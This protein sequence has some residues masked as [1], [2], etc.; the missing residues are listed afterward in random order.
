MINRLSPWVLALSMLL[1]IGVACA[2]T[3]ALAP[4]HSALKV[5]ATESF[6]ADIAQNVAGSRAQIDTLIP[7]GVD[8][9]SFEPTPADI[10]KVADSH[11]LIIN[12][13]G[14]EAFLERLLQNAG[15]NRLLIEASKGLTSRKPAAGEPVDADN[16]IDPHFWLDPNNVVQYVETIRDGL[17]QVDPDGAAVYAANASAYI[18]KLKALD[19]WITAQVQPVSP[20]RR[21]LVTNHEEFG[22][23]ADRYGFK[24]IGAIIPSFSTDASPSAQQLAQLIGQIRASHAPAIFLEV[25]ANPQMANQ[26]ARETGVKVVTNLYTHSLSDAHGPAPTYIDMMKYDTQTIVRALE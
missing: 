6:L 5:L 12:G 19:Q 26:V 9:H 13:G 10:K 23:F 21:L 18:A 24:I 22:Y 14:M 8:P 20:A 3:P 25:S 16:P 7:I 4:G 15:G 1:V 2:P 17:R 11:V